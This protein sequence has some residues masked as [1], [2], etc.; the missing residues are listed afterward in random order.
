MW[1]FQG[2]KHKFLKLDQHLIGALSLDMRIGYLN[3]GCLYIPNVASLVEDV[4]P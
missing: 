2:H 1:K 3:A 4:K